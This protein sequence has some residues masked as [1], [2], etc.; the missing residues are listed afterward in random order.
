[1]A[2]ILSILFA[3]LCIS[4]SALAQWELIN[5]ESTLNFISVKKSAVAEVH[6]FKSL[7]GTLD[8]KGII[9][10]TVDLSSAETGIAIRNDRLKSMLFEVASFPKANIKASVDPKKIAAMQA[11]DSIILPINFKASL[12]GV[13]EKIPADVRIIK[14][15]GNRLLALSVKPIIINTYTYKLSDGIE[16][17]RKAAKLPSISTAVPVSF[18]F[19][20]NQR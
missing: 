10:V 19:I 4:S 18:S 9:S 1:M 16:L 13:S 6:Q 20:F 12:H 2:K 3:T 11:G 15:S 5:D 7:S 14:L 8:K 17:L